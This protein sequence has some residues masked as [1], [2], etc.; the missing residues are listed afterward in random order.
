MSTATPER[1]EVVTEL[2]DHTQLPD[3]DGAIVENFQ[4]HPQGRLLTDSIEPVLNRIHPDHWYCIGQDSGI[5][6]KQ[7]DPPLRGAIAPDWFYV[8]GVPPTLDG[9]MRRSYV[10]WKE[11]E[12]PLIVLE[13]ASGDGSE[14]RDDTPDVGKFWIYERRIRP[15]F[16]GIYEVDPGRIEMYR[17]VEHRFERMTP[18]ERGH[19]PIPQIHAEVGIWHGTYQDAE[20]PWMRWWD[21]TGKLLLTGHEIAQLERVAVEEERQR[22]EQERQRAEREQQRAELERQRAEKLEAQLRRLGVEPEA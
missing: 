8:A 12:A 5:Y 11:L 16:Y 9:Q 22:A 2:P 19:F 17:F 13:F 15:A 10:L 6:W 1:P 14:E 20:L 4:E 7:T 3:S 18:N 21:L